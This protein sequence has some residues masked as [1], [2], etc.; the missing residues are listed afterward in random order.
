MIHNSYLL[1]NIYL[2][3]RV[4]FCFTSCGLVTLTLLPQSFKNSHFPLIN[5][6][7]FFHFAPC[8]E[9]NEKIDNLDEVR[10]WEQNEKT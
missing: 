7:W 3:T 4:N 5:L 6:L 9:Q 8:R 10:G 1:L 2:R